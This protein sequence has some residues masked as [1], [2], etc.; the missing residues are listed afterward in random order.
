MTSRMGPRVIYVDRHARGLPGVGSSTWADAVANNGTSDAGPHHLKESI[1]ALEEAF[2]DGMFPCSRLPSPPLPSL[3]FV[4]VHVCSSSSS[5]LSTLSALH[6]AS[7]VDHTPTIVLIDIPYDERVPERRRRSSSRSRSPSPHSDPSPPANQEESQISD[8]E[9]YG[10]RLLQRIVAEADMLKLM[11][12][13]VP[14]PVLSLPPMHQAGSSP[15][16]TEVDG[17]AV[18]RS[19]ISMSSPTSHSSRTDLIRTCLDYGAVDVMTS[20]LQPQNIESLEVHAYKAHQAA[21]RERETAL[22]ARKNRKRSW[23]GVD[24]GG[25][26]FAY[27]RE[28]MVSSLMRGICRLDD[29]DDSSLGT[30]RISISAERQAQIAEAV[31]QWH[32]CAHDFSD[33]ELV[34]AASLMFSHALSMPELEQWR[35]P[36]GVWKLIRFFPPNRA[37]HVGLHSSCT[38]TDRHS[39]RPTH[40]VRHCLSC[41]IQ[42]LCTLP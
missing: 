39:A 9:L 38:R 42:Q 24:T 31:G 2:G 8:V 10:L 12:L 4:A 26:P 3:T 14:I 33:D 34:V 41:C 5:C 18:G 16:S 19:H 17:G 32:F 25:K 35:I 28:A 22:Q 15:G 36:P 13:V 40:P 29:D 1:T 7:T 27:L 6:H 37:Y 11:K 23:V 20:P 21:A 30:F